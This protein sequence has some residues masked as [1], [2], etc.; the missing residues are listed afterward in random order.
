MPTLHWDV[1]TRS[2]ANLTLVGAWKYATDPTTETLCIAYAVDDDA[3]TIWLPTDP[4]PAPFL[5][6]AVDPADW[7]V[8]A[9]NFE[10]ERAVLEHVLAPR[11]GFQP[12]ALE[13]WHCSQ[14]L[15]MANAYPAELGL[16][17]E[18]LEL[19]Y[20]KDPKA[21]RALL[22]VSR[23]R[24]RSRG[25]TKIEWCEDADKLQLVCERC[26]LDVVTMRAVWQHPKLKHL[27]ETERRYQLLDTRI[28]Q[29][30]VAIDRAFVTAARTLAVRERN[31][32]NARLADLTA[33]TIT[34]V[35]QIKRLLAAVNGHGHQ[36]TTL[37]KRSVAA[38]LAHKPGDYVRELLELRRAGARASVRKFE[39]LLSYAGDDDRIRGSLRMY[40]AGPGRWAG[41]G[42]QLQNLKRNES[43]L[44]L[45]VVDAVRSGDRSLI[46]QFGNPLTL[47]GDISRAAICAAPGHL[48]IAADFSAVESRVLAWLAQEQWKLEAYR[49]YDATGD[50]GLEPYQIVAAQMLRKD[51]PDVTAEERQLGKAAE[52]AAGFGGSIG[53]WRRILPNDERSDAEIKAIIDKWRRAHPRTQKLWRDFEKAIPVAIRTGQLVRIGRGNLGSVIETYYQNDNLYLTLPSGRQI[54]YPEARLLPNNKFE[55]GRPNVGFKDNARKQWTDYRGWFGTFIENVVQGTARDLLA[56][57]IER[58]EARGIPVVLHCHDDIAVEVPAGTL[59]EAEF[60]RIML[61]P[62]AWAE[63]L[64]L[65]GK[66][67]CGAHYL[68][69]PEQAAEPQPADVAELAIDQYVASVIPEL[70]QPEHEETTGEMLTEL[71]EREAPLFEL[72]SPRTENNKVCCPFHADATPS[73]QLYADHYHC[74][75]CGAHG[76]RMHWLTQ[77]EELTREEAIALIED[78]HDEPQLQLRLALDDKAEKTA[79]ALELWHKAGPIAGTLA[80]RYLA[81]TRTIDVSKLPTNIGDSLRFLGRCPFGPKQKRPCL[82]ALMRDPKTD[83]PLGIHR[84]GL[85]LVNGEVHRL[86]RMALGHMGV[87]KLWPAGDRLVVGEGIET[88]LA[89][90]TRIPYQGAALT[91]AWSAVTEAGLEHLPVL[92]D[93][94]QL[95]VLA[96]HDRNGVGQKA[97]ARC[98]QRW[99]AAGR[100]AVPLLPNEP[101][102]DFN[103]IVMR[104]RP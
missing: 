36:M 8:V 24:K 83:A 12:I 32:I 53:A 65:A 60:L 6:A 33:G 25:N 45:S 56:A 91:P 18:A 50:K 41:T 77:V 57:A 47:L 10:F 99:Q 9:H 29:R 23:P 49:H 78:W 28:N 11:D 2:V 51:A 104:R 71:S 101:G 37:G 17:S 30:G 42:P 5:A 63:G 13:A 1:E 4:V 62:P 35:D 75:A 93:V 19:P 95:I 87:V 34:S 96:D 72:V 61:E 7:Q 59:A 90:A 16:L 100:T 68:E 66:V 3:V 38:L 26:R 102:T 55:G 88:T 94:R 52:L 98:V 15:A 44:P 22:D 89:A 48:L 21:R 46:A 103:D 64:P 81:E 85:K 79:G 69:P 74:F 39:R 14:R 43:N 92:S 31:A 58:L 86:D 27:S 20:R 76:D 73:C 82:L 97:A 84:I 54:T 80:E 70:E 40:G 67:R